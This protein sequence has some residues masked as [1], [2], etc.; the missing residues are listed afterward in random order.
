MFKKKIFTIS[1]VMMLV[2]VSLFA[3]PYMNAMAS[4][5]TKVYTTY[6]EKWKA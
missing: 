2:F 3:M 1:T 6:V 4:G 5:N